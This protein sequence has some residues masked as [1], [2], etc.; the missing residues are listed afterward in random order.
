MV[1]RQRSAFD[2]SDWPED[3]HVTP[4]WEDHEASANCP[5]CPRVTY[6]HPVTKARIWTHRE[7]N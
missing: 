3:Q 7:A 6:E 4:D 2:R 5:C 1:P